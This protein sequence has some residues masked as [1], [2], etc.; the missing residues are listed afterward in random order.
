MSYYAA[1]LQLFLR[2]LA[3]YRALQ[4]EK[5]VVIIHVASVQQIPFNF[6]LAS[7]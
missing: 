4:M 7:N 3:M 5:Y 1:M 2:F 6:F